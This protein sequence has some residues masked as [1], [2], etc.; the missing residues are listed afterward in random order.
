MPPPHSIPPTPTLSPQVLSNILDLGMDP[1]S[2][3]DAP[4]FCVDR[5]DSTVGA[6]SVAESHV[7]LEEGIDPAV[8]KELAAMGHNVVGGIVEGQG[9]TVFGRGQ[10]GAFWGGVG[11]VAGRG[12]SWARSSVVRRADRA[13]EAAPAPLPV[14][15]LACST[16]KPP[17]L[18]SPPKVIWRDIE[19]GVLMGASDPRNDG[20]AIGY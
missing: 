3:L 9:R 15:R 7:F 17:A 12:V 11:R 5:A 18:A 14:L 20:C 8:A 4:R 10:V 19:T 2:A 16:P 13:S 1:Q 6:A